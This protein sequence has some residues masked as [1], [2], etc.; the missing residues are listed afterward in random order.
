M[1]YSRGWRASAPIE[2]CV[3][4]LQPY[5]YKVCCVKSQDNVADALSRLTKIPASEKYRYDDEHVRM[6]ALIAVSTALTRLRVPQLGMRI[7]KQYKVVLGTGRRPQSHT[8]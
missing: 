3:L 7:Y 2:R 6:A 1:T 8:Q 4:R 5:S